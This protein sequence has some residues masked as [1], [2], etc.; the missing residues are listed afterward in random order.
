MFQTTPAR[1]DLKTP[2]VVSL[3]GSREVSPQVTLLAEVQWTNWSV[4]K[5]LRIERP[6]GSALT[7]QPE[8]WHGTWFASVGATYRPDPSWV[9]RGGLAFDP[10][11]VRN[12]FRTARL[13]DSDRYWLS[14]GLGYR[15][16][17]DLRFDAAYAHIFAVNPSINEMSQTSDLLVGR[18]SNHIDIVSLSA[19]LR[20]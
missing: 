17:S 11:P 4:V 20:F 16:T 2:D 6:D 12:Q 8:Q 13:P 18:Y 1:A 14:L 10:T 19:T 15:W 7:D 9:I 5:N 3:A